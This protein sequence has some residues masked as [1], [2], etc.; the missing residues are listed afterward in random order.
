MKKVANYGFM[1]GVTSNCL[2]IYFVPLDYEEFKKKH[3][4]LPTKQERNSL[5]WKSTFH[6][7]FFPWF[8]PMSFLRREG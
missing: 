6:S 2:T 1:Y 5:V 4:R 7:L 3:G 8:L